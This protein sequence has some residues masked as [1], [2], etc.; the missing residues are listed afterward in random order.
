MSYVIGI[1][2]GTAGGKSTFTE[3][4]AD[5]LDGL[6]VK[7][8][9]MD[10]YY[11]SET[12][13]PHVA[14]HINGNVYMDDNCPE[15]IDLDRFVVD[16][17]DAVGSNCDVVI[18]E[19]LFVLHDERIKN[20]LSLKLFVDC[21]ADERIVRRIRRNAEW[22]QSFDT[23]TDVYLNM[24]RFRHEQFVEPTKWVAD[25]IINGSGD[26]SDAVQLLAGHVKCKLLRKN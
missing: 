4:L 14:S 24:V 2:G 20:K 10:S 3:K 13:R 15:C 23:V 19:G 5:S 1:A 17:S 16:L 18:A 8:L 9:H 6:C 11:K 22:G 25:L 12:D 21:P 26:T 7:V